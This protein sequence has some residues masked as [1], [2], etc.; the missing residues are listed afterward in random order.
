MQE[1]SSKT[2]WKRIKQLPIVRNILA[3]SMRN[4]LPGFK[5]Q[6]IYTIIKFIIKEIRKDRLV[7]RANSISFSFFISLFPT[8]ITFFTLIP[9]IFP[10]IFNQYIINILPTNADFAY[11]DNGSVDFSETLILQ[12][13]A[14]IPDSI[15]QKQVLEVVRD[16]VSKPKPGLFSLGF[17]LAIFFASN[18]MQSMMLG[19]EKSY[20]KTFKKR[21]DFKKRL[22][23]IGL[24]F[25]I[26]GMFFV[27]I[28]L[29]ILTNQL[30]AFAPDQESPP[31]L[32]N[33]LIQVF[34]FFI[35][36][37]L[38]YMSVSM[39]YRYGA[40]TITKTKIFSVGAT[41]VVIGS[42]IST[43]LFS[44]YLSNFVSFDQIYGSIG[45]I[46]IVM[47]WIQLIV[48]FLLIGYELNAAIAVNRD[49]AKGY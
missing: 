9:L 30:V 43:A 49:L 2:L 21:K 8:I 44:I 15:G 25:L 38:F 35:I 11:H 31:V 4:S 47:L 40:S 10:Y 29:L 14:F 23:A 48:L 20:P 6:P 7:T 17:L 33:L 3:W 37:G 19:F 46:I 42:A 27:T 26:A 22:I 32:V 13:D 1:T 39:I 24:L 34:R 28:L 16:I 18:G 5:G 41:L 45:S 36:A 12:L